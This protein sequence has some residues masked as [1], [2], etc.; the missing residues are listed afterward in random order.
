MLTHSCTTPGSGVETGAAAATSVAA[1]RRQVAEAVAGGVVVTADGGELLDEDGG[2]EL[3]VVAL[4]HFRKPGDQLVVRVRWG[5]SQ[6]LYPLQ[7]VD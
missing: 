2:V 6:L 5:S 4:R 1:S 3:D 7:G